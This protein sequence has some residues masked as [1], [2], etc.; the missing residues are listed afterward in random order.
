MPL[1]ASP[2]PRL[3]VSGRSNEARR[4]GASS[5]RSCMKAL[6]ASGPAFAAA[7]GGAAGGAA[8]ARVAAT[9]SPTAS[10]PARLA[11]A[12]LMASTSWTAPAAFATA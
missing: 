5:G 7:A 4:P 2:N 9:V 6:Q 12:F 11:A 8:W 3:I 1:K 10:D